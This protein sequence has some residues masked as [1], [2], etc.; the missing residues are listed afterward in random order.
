[1][2]AGLL[3]GAV[4]DTDTVDIIFSESK[5]PQRIEVGPD[6]FALGDRHYKERSELLDDDAAA[7]L[8]QVAILFSYCE[9][10]HVGS[11]YVQRLQDISRF[12]IWIRLNEIALLSARLGHVK[13]QWRKSS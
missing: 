6:E 13:P 3:A 12:S 7:A 11:D 1:M 10:T 9:S 4:P 2:G 5:E 8:V